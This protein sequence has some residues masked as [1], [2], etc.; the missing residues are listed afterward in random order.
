MIDKYLFSPIHHQS[1]SSEQFGSSALE[2]YAQSHK[3]KNEEKLVL[4]HMTDS[5]ST[6]SIEIFNLG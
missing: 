5:F 3:G 4:L 6:F 1:L 2:E